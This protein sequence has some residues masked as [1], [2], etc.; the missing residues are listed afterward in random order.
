[1]TSIPHSLAAGNEMDEEVAPR[2]DFVH[3]KQKQL[4]SVV[5]ERYGGV[6]AA[7]ALRKLYRPK[8]A[9]QAPAAEAEAEGEGGQAEAAEGEGGGAAEQAAAAAGESTRHCSFLRLVSTTIS[10]TSTSSSSSIKQV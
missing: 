2:I 7:K 3:L 8:A 6:K 4:P 1:M 10:S 5:F 9:K